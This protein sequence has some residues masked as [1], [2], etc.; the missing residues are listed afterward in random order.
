MH[1][2]PGACLLH[3]PR[4]VCF[5]KYGSGAYLTGKLSFKII[6]DPR[7]FGPGPY[8]LDH[9]SRPKSQKCQLTPSPQPSGAVQNKGF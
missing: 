9:I 7:H 2:A 4:A 5:F 8:V 1:A 3:A 6:N